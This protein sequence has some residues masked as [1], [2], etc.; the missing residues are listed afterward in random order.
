MWEKKWEFK[1]CVRVVYP[2]VT[3]NSIKN[4]I[5]GERPSFCS[6]F[7]V[8]EGRVQSVIQQHLVV[9]GGW[10]ALFI[11]WQTHKEKKVWQTMEKIICIDN[12]VKIADEACYYWV[13][14]VQSLLL[15]INQTLYHLVEFWESELTLPL[16]LYL[17]LNCVP[18]LSWSTSQIPSVF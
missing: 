3:V 7:Y 15:I 12:K 5:C 14:N 16:S 13:V 18:F 6:L 17:S 10:C 9:L 4:I 8:Q 1:L 2:A 11:I